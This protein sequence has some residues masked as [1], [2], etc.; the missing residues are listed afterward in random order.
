MDRLLGEVNLYMENRDIVF[1]IKCKNQY[2]WKN[3]RNAVSINQHRL[4]DGSCAR[5]AVHNV[6][7]VWLWM[8]QHSEWN[9]VSSSETFL[10]FLLVRVCK[11]HLGCCLLTIEEN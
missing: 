8:G 4:G 10:P 1:F 3:P 11:M 9:S 6:S 2:F 5:R 7:S